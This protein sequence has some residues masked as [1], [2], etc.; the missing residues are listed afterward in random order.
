ML[1][2]VLPFGSRVIAGEGA[3]VFF[4]V[5]GLAFSLISSASTVIRTRDAVILI[6]AATIMWGIFLEGH[7]AVNMIRCLAVA[8]CIVFAVRWL[9]VRR[10]SSGFRAIAWRDVITAV[11]AV[12]IAWGVIT[13]RI[14]ALGMV[15]FITFA[16]L[17]TVGLLIGRGLSSGSAAGWRVCL[18]TV[19]PAILAGIGGLIYRGIV[20]G[21][22]PV[23]API[24]QS[25]VV[26][27]FW[28]L[29]LG[30]AVGLGISI[31]SEVVE[32]MAGRVR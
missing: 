18:G 12:S 27:P 13:A 32:W 9:P 8:T 1:R 28:G 4:I 26:G 31:G 21:L 5:Y 22:G 20:G 25:V 11:L 16:S 14:N 3:F 24:G 15:R 6:L 30:L 19:P 7:L 10:I 17:V 29:S 2:R 23:G